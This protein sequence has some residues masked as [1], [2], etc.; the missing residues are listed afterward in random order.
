M[1]WIYTI[2]LKLTA[3]LSVLLI[4][5][6]L[7]K[8][9]SERHM[10]HRSQISLLAL[11]ERNVSKWHSEL[12]DTQQST[13]QL[14][15]SPTLEGVG[16]CCRTETSAG[17]RMVVKVHSTKPQ[18][19]Y[20]TEVIFYNIHRFVPIQFQQRNFN[21]CTS[22]FGLV[23]VRISSKCTCN[24]LIRVRK[25]QTQVHWLWQVERLLLSV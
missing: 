2:Y 17:P 13:N 8:S 16:D 6:T 9:L 15:I 12:L 23:L 4:S 3:F 18:G 21:R 1:I 20:K 10:S 22:S 24:V 25:R 11:D 5:C 14:F 7:N 19:I